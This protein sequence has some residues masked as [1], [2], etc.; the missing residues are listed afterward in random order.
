MAWLPIAGAVA[1][2]VLGKLKN[3]RAQEIESSDRKLAAETQRYSPWTG[4]QAQPIH[5]AGSQFGDVF[6][7]GVG[8]AITGSQL[9]STMNG[10]PMPG[11]S[12]PMASGGGYTM[13]GAP[14]GQYNLGA[15]QDQFAPNMYSFKK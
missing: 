7:G 4:M 5:R 13:D 14:G 6:G 8:G 10:A 12:Q 2:G 1:G 9:G 3:D 15:P 11:G